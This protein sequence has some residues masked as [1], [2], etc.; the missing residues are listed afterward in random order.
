MRIFIIVILISAL[1]S[2]RKEKLQNHGMNATTYHYIGTLA[3]DTITDST[4]TRDD[5]SLVVGS[6]NEWTGS[7][8]V[9]IVKNEY[10]MRQM[11]I[12]AIETKR[13]PENGND[14]VQYFTNKDSQGNY[15]VSVINISD[16]VQVPQ[17]PQR[18]LTI[19]DFPFKGWNRFVEQ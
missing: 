2:C 16:G 14:F 9:S 7:F 10:V 1:A 4:F 12:M 19:V 8:M 17:L 11:K 15:Y 5:Y 13:I 6:F 3:N 18:Y